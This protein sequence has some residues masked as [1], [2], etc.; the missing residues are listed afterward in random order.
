MI[1][2]N[3]TRKWHK[4]N[5]YMCHIRHNFQSVVYINHNLNF[6]ELLESQLDMCHKCECP[7]KNMFDNFQ[8][9][10]H[11]NRNLPKI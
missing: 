4:A 9:V 6:D 5:N 2:G 10:V 8:F 11:I 3:L 7:M 1:K